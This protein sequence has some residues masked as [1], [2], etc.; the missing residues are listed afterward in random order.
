MFEKQSLIRSYDSL[1]YIGFPVYT[2]VDIRGERKSCDGQKNDEEKWRKAG[3]DII[4]EL[5]WNK[6]QI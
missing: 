1:N 3:N 5:L 6:V 2:S 4:E